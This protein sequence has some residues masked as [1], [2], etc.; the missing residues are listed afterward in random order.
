[1]Q[2]NKAPIIVSLGGSLIVPGEIDSIFLK[3]FSKLI[4]GLVAE[5][6]RFV[7]ITG[8][9]RTARNYQVAASSVVK[10]END[11]IDWLG[12]HA[13]R[14]NAH[15]IRTIFHDIAYPRI[16]KHPKEKIKWD[17]PLLVAAGWK[18]GFS[19]DYDAVLIAKQVGAKTI[20][21]LSN[22]SH[23]YS[24]DPKT[25]KDAKPLNNISWADYRRIIPA[26]WQ[27]GL[28]SPFDPIAS[29]L[30]HKSGL[31]VLVTNGSDLINLKN[32]L[33][34]RKFRGTTIA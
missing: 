34:G 21:N 1:M 3:K 16:I 10:L 8:G 18:P 5:G 24:G 17:G 2:N 6:Q 33:L 20:I 11:D 25:D 28:N 26:E 27:P 29:K 13:T 7:L 31:Q 30:A 15:L 22:I 32:A 23:V 14:I 19:T 12:I 4:H 9:G